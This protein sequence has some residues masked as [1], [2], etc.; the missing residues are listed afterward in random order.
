L[1]LTVAQ[2]C[3]I[4]LTVLEIV[5][6]VCASLTVTVTLFDVADVVVVPSEP[7]PLSVAVSLT[8][9]CDSSWLA[10]KVHE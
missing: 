10:V 5:P 1:Y 6:V 2:F 7:T 9:G 3:V 4:E 8:L